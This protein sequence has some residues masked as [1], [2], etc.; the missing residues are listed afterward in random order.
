MYF[1]G[2]KYFIH[3]S[4]GS[5]YA[6]IPGAYH[7]DS[8]RSLRSRRFYVT[9]FSENRKREAEIGDRRAQ[10]MGKTISIGA[11]SFEF[12]RENDYFFVNKS[13][14]IREWWEN[15]DAVTLVTRPRRFGK[16]LNL[17]MLYC[18]F[19]AKYE[20]R[21]DLFEG[22]SIWEE[23]KYRKLQGTCPVIFLTFADIKGSTFEKTKQGMKHTLAKLYETHGYEAGS[24]LEHAFDQ[25][26]PEGS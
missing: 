7:Y 3:V 14:L 15:G 2:V 13:G 21:D 10:G 25:R 12:I 23:E 6:P 5:C 22:L 20:G 4:L 17:N 8:D 26:I 19:S 18:F 16:T 11:Q 9:M 1:Y 24:D